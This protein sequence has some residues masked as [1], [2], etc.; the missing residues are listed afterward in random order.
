MRSCA[1]SR[2]ASD[3][4][5]NFSL[6]TNVSIIRRSL[7]FFL[8]FYDKTHREAK[9]V[10]ILD[11]LQ[12]SLLQYFSSFF[13]SC[14]CVHA[15]CVIFHKVLFASFNLT[16]YFFF[17]QKTRASYFLIPFSRAH[18]HILIFICHSPYRI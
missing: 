7:F 14:L 6:D 4:P 12:F 10:I 1:S 3:L 9:P 18:T 16:E 15:L 5:A 11:G 13:L 2:G 8:L 17:L